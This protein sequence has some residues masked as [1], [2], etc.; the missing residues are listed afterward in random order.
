MG[1]RSLLCSTREHA[2]DLV[3]S[4]RTLERTSRSHGDSGLH[5]LRHVNMGGRTRRHLGQVGD[6]ENLAPLSELG[7][8]RCDRNGCFP[9]DPCVDFIEHDTLW[10]RSED[11]P[12]R[13][14]GSG[15]LTT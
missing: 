15:E 6:D 8:R 10:P 3:D 9:A 14:H 5:R 11:Q 12:E 4:S 7:Q 1:H 13:Q 2:G